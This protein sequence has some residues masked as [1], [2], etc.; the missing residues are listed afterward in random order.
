[1]RALAVAF[2][3]A[4]VAI[5]WSCSKKPAYPR[6]DDDGQCAVAGRHDYCVAGTCA[7]CRTAVDCA[8]R[9]KCS[10]GRCEHDPLLDPP[11]AGPDAEADAEADSGDEPPLRRKRVI[12]LEDVE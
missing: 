2:V 7:Y 12:R 4:L 6:C 1:L 3:I 8:E 11:D 10:A 9:E 5:A